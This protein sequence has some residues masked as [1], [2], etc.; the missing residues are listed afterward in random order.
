MMPSITLDYEARPAQGTLLPPPNK[1]RVTDL[2]DVEKLVFI[3]SNWQNPPA[4]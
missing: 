4:D 1:D 2:D 3:Q